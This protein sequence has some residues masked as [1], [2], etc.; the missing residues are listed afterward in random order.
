MKFGQKFVPL[1]VTK[2][3]QDL[4]L[5]ANILLNKLNVYFQKPLKVTFASE[6]ILF[7]CFLP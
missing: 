4:V 6:P 7:D 3:E 5:L 2:T 1:L